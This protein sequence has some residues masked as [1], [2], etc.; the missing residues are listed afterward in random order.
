MF[1]S[2]GITLMGWTID[3]GQLTM[4]ELVSK[5]TFLLNKITILKLNPILFRRR[6]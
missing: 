4:E 5:N 2:V 1:I 3:S 6:Y